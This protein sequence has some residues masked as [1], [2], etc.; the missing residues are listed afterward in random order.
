MDETDSSTAGQRPPR[1]LSREARRE[2]LIEATI[3][4][5]A[6]RGYARTTLTDVAR[7]AGLSHGLVN[8]H[9]ETKEK[10]FGET[11]SFLAEEYRRNWTT[12]I[13]AAGPE[14]ALR[15]DAMIR[16]DF[17]PEICTPSRLAAWCA[18]WG[19]AQSRPLYQDK[20][21]SNDREYNRV[22]EEIC[23]DLLA[24]TGRTG[25]SKARR[26]C[27]PGD[28]RGCLARPD[29]DERP[30]RQGRSAAYGLHLRCGVLSPA[31]SRIAE[32]WSP[33]HKSESSA[34]IAQVGCGI[35]GK[36]PPTTALNEPAAS[37]NHLRKTSSSRV[38]FCA[39][40]S[41]SRAEKDW[42]CSHSN[43]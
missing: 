2:Q 32:S 17:N 6:R 10:L 13:E 42:R 24:E 3:E 22:L 19:E 8:F 29:D 37:P 26:T 9:F 38:T 25:R 34:T 41:R 27:H 30:L 1:K 15:L 40:A 14:P 33:A 5:I 43:P 39:W 18:F 36:T 20:C 28:D 23:R 21:G 11:M 16:A 31:C 12:A 7:H 35:A 4:I